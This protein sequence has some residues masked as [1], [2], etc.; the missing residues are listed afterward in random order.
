MSLEP[1]A[2]TQISPALD[3]LLSRPGDPAHSEYKGLSNLMHSLLLD[4]VLTISA[5]RSYAALLRSFPFP[6]TWP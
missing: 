2:L 1:P 6:P 3:I 5:T 4:S